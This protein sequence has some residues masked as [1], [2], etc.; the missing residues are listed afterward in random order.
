MQCLSEKPPFQKHIA[1]FALSISICYWALA[2]FGVRVSPHAELARFWNTFG[3]FCLITPAI[4]FHFTLLLRG[5]IIRPFALFLIYVPAIIIS[6]LYG[7]TDF[8]IIGYQPDEWRWKYLM[9]TGMPAFYFISAVAGGFGLVLSGFCFYSWIHS[10]N[11][12]KGAI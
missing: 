3:M 8:V 7:L 5:M 9:N 12:K 11:A 2:G 6:L 4:L 1:F 10:E